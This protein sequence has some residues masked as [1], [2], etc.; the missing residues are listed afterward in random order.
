MP[1]R[2]SI[3]LVARRKWHG[4]VEARH[5]THLHSSP[6]PILRVVFSGGTLLASIEWWR[7]LMD[8]DKPSLDDPLGIADAPVPK[9][10][11][12]IHAT[13]DP[14]EVARRRARARGETEPTVRGPGADVND[15]GFG[16]TSIDMGYGGEGNAIRKNRP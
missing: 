15:D 4:W 13:N 6:V 5:Y 8:K 11:N 3:E 10:A 1:E 12:D 16:A 2:Q 7:D 9:D 14:D